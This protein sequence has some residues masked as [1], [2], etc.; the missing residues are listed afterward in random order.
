MPF[1][2]DTLAVRAGQQRTAE[3]EHSE[4]LFLTS[5]YVF[6]NAAEA[7]AR[8][9][10][11]EPGNVYS[12]YTN[13]TVRTFEQ[14]LAA[15]EGAEQAVATASGMSAILATVMA[16]CST[17][18]HVLVSRSVFGSTISL[19]EKY[20][21]R[22]GVQVDYP[23]LADLSAWQ[24]AFKANTK[25]LLVE[26]PSNPLIELVDIAA[27]AELA[28][29][30]GALLA[31]DNCFCTPALQQPLKLSAD[32]VIHSATKYIDG[33]GRCLGGAVAG[34]QQQMQEVVGFLRTAGPTL[35]PFNAWIMLKGLETLSIRMQAQSARAFELARWL[36]QQSAI[37]Q[38]YYAGLA[39]HPQ[40]ELAKRQQSAFGAVLSFKVKG[41]RDE[42]WRFI[43]A[44]R[45]IS[46]TTN[47]GDTKTTIAHPASTSHGRLS[48]DERARAGVTDNL[49]RLAVGLED[50]KDLKAD[51]AL[52]LA[53]LG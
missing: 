14:R 21:K 53:A 38:V 24:A 12:R 23:P 29:S 37:E 15:L 42:A 34:R 17:G 39:S 7:A 10:G 4:A 19:F 33:Q 49:I 43:D 31:V 36:T 52:G 18:D 41:G 40:H 2:F 32:I 11:A 26:S 16:L 8:F 35:S 5:S 20:L 51:L 48:A 47:L 45:M 46:I 28:H 22:F 9:A 25:L 27:L 6:K 30:H 50:V 13:P 44:T 3:G 1:S